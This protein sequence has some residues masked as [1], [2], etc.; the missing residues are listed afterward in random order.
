MK[1]TRQSCCGW[2]ATISCACPWTC[3]KLFCLARG[4]DRLGHGALAA[5]YDECDRNLMC[6]AVEIGDGQSSRIRL[7][8]D[9]ETRKIG[10]YEPEVT[11]GAQPLLIYVSAL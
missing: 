10:T 8:Q 1:A 3:R 11:T 7:A 9:S 5:Q 2:S 6:L 4:R